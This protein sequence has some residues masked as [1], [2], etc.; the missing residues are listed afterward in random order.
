MA[1]DDS[2]FISPDYSTYQDD[3]NYT[4]YLGNSGYDFNPAYTDL[5]GSN[6]FAPYTDM[7]YSNP[8]LDLYGQLADA[9]IISSDQYG[10]PDLSSLYQ[11][12]PDIA[13]QVAGGEEWTPGQMAE[14]SS[15]LSN[16]VQAAFQQAEALDPTIRDQVQEVG[17]GLYATPEGNTLDLLQLADYLKKASPESS[18]FGWGGFESAIPVDR[19]EVRPSQS[20]L[21]RNDDVVGMLSAGADVQNPYEYRTADNGETYIQDIRNGMPIGWLDE[22]MQP[23]YYQD[24]RVSNLA[25]QGLPTSTGGLWNLMKALPSQANT[26]SRL[27]GKEAPQQRAVDGSLSKPQTALNSAAMAAMIAEALRNKSVQAQPGIYDKRGAEKW[28]V[29]RAAGSGRKKLA[30]GGPAGGAGC[31]CGALGQIR[32]HMKAGGQADVVRAD[33]SGGEYVLDADVVAALGDGDSDAGAA[34]LDQMREAVRT[35]KRSAP[36]SKIPPKAKSPLQYMKGKK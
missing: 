2:E 33:L 3:P 22:S 9:G 6:Q 4:S 19:N 29:G 12:S 16:P 11:M 1:W 13:Q 8:M 18:R 28:S 7:D 21:D 25:E 34:R 27:A 17:N 32:D 26:M 10:M 31:G 20:Y 30:Q 35:H 36:A 23:R 5:Y 14:F 24:E 15:S